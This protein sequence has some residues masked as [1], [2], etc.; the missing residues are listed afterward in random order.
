MTSPCGPDG[1]LNLLVFF[2]FLTI[3]IRENFQ[4]VIE[5]LAGIYIFFQ[6]EL[7]SQFAA[8]QLKTKWRLVKRK[9]KNKRKWNGTK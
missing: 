5:K 4:D 6:L 8:K 2:K 9:R 1:C 7:T 3:K